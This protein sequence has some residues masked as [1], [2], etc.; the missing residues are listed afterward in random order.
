MQNNI[1]FSTTNNYQD[2]LPV[3]LS[4]QVTPSVEK[5]YNNNDNLFPS[6]ILEVPNR[7]NDNNQYCNTLS[8]PPHNQNINVPY[9]GTTNCPDPKYQ[10][11]NND[12][13]C[14]LYKS[15]AQNVVGIV[16]NQPGGSN[17]ANFS[18]GNQF[19]ID[20]PYNLNN[21]LE[22]KKLEYTVES[23]IQL[24]IQKQNPVM[25]TE[26]NDFYPYPS[27]SLMKNKNF[28]TYPKTATYT[29]NGIPTYV[30]PYKVMNPETITKNSVPQTI[31]T[32]DNSMP[33]KSQVFMLFL[34]LSIIVLF[35]V[36]VNMKKK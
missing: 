7:K 3:P 18:R 10:P 11:F 24:P 4:D 22:N 6:P 28:L 23:P 20:K 30:Y 29:E 32:F 34:L 31:E 26:P 14:Y 12:D 33:A 5:P 17:N 13:S 2:I 25:I 35:I 15:N 16:C 36:Y 8:P 21:E 27:Q 19:G 9:E 1:L